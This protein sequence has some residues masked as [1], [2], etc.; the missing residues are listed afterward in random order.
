MLQISAMR[1]LW[2][3]LSLLGIAGCAVTRTARL[4]DLSS[5]MVLS[6]SY[7]YSGTGRGRIFTGDEKLP[8]CQGEYVTVAGGET[9]WGAIYTG[10]AVAQAVATTTAN[11][12]RGS[13][14][15]TCK[16]GVVITCE[17]VT[18]ALNGAGSGACT[19]S[20]QRRYRLMF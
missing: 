7:K 19:D 3:L 9:A 4:Y 20:A 12:Q 11:E 14:I 2:V 10:T 17:Y 6:A 15:L 1:R 5:G 13:A 8:V 18:S 16:D